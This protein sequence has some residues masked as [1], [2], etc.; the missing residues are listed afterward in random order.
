MAPTK[1]MVIR[2]AEKPADAGTPFGVSSDG[3]QDSEELIVRGWQ[4]AGALVRFFAPVNGQF[5]HPGLATPD[6]IFAS[7][8]AP[9]SKSLRPQH[10]V[11]ALADWLGQQLDL[12]YAKNDETALVADALSESGTVLIAWEHE[13]IPVIANQ[14][15]GDQSTCPQQWPGDRFDVVWVFDSAADG[16][17]SF[18]QIPQELLPGDGNTVIG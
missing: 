15:V 17:W 10:T 6:V 18:S 8:V 16:G 9:H 1:I 5:S 12:S 13:K 11:L 3:I 14:I 7:G 4:R 2:H